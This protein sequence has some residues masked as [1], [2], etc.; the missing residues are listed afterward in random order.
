MQEW[1]GL[2]LNCEYVHIQEIWFTKLLW[3]ADLLLFIFFIHQNIAQAYF[4]KNTDEI[5]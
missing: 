4:A 1:S 3:W 2:I 5:I